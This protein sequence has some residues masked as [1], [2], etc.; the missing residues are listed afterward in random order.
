MESK[1]LISKGNIS[2]RLMNNTKKDMK[3]LLN[4]LTNEQVVRWVYEEGA[5]WGMNKIVEQFAEK[6]EEGGSS[7][8]CLIVYNKQEIGY[9][10]YYP[11]EKDSYKF[12]SQDLFEKVAEGYGLDMFIGKPELWNK[13][14]GTLAIGL[15]EEYLKNNM[16][17]KVLCVDPITDNSRAVHFWQKV[18]FQPIDIIEAYDNGDQK[19]ILMM[20]VL[21]NGKIS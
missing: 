10:Q 19:S 4:W 12:N 3:L 18:G 20:K 8:P 9:L 5:P 13:G 6:T 21:V 14:I 17:V 2:L 7:I 16:N 11:I 15:V 1:T